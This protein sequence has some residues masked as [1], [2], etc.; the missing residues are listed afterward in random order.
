MKLKEKENRKENADQL[1][2]IIHPEQDTTPAP[3]KS[4]VAPSPAFQTKE[5]LTN[6]E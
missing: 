2:K 1:E 6:E 3:D 5:C 4:K